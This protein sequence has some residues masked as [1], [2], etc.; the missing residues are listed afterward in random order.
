MPNKKHIPHYKKCKSC[1][2]HE[3][4][5]SMDKMIENY[6]QKINECFDKS[7]ISNIAL[8]PKDF[9]KELIENG[10]IPP[11]YIDKPLIFRRK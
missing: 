4:F 2:F 5:L 3:Q 10:S 9:K 6:T 1:P 7:N 8:V 11:E